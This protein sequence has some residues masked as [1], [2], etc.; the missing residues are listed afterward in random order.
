MRKRFAPGLAVAVAVV[1]GAS[2]ALLILCRRAPGEPPLPSL[3]TPG[4]ENSSA[5]PA[6]RPAAGSDGSDHAGVPRRQEKHSFDRRPSS[7]TEWEDTAVVPR[8][9]AP[10][11]IANATTVAPTAPTSTPT[12]PPSLPKVFQREFTL[13]VGRKPTHLAGVGGPDDHLAFLGADRFAVHVLL[14]TGRERRDVP[15]RRGPEGSGANLTPVFSDG[16]GC[17][18]YY[19]DTVRKPA[20]GGVFLAEYQPGAPGRKRAGAPD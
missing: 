5:E 1:L 3:P 10:T 17:T 8:V 12:P 16:Y 20:A 14:G 19:V 7:T 9:P 15:L 11:T 4:Q 13:P 2:A 18:V 6:D